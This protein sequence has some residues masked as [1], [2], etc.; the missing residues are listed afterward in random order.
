M[1]TYILVLISVFLTFEWTFS[2]NNKTSFLETEV[3][4][5]IVSGS[6]H[7]TLTTPIPFKK[8]TVAL[9][10]AGSGPT[11]RNGNNVAME[12]NSL[13]NLAHDLAKNGIATLRYDKRGIAASQQALTRE[14]DLRFEDLVED[15]KGWVFQL[16]KDKKY[17]RIVVIGHSEGS[18]IGM[19]AAKEADQFISLAGAG[20]S[21]DLILKEQLNNQ[22]QML[23]DVA[24]PIIDSLKVG[25]TVDKINPLLQSLFRKSVQPY[26]ISWFKY[27]PAQ[28]LKK[29]N[30]PTLLIQGDK[31]IQVGVEDA[32][33]LAQ[34]VPSA[35]LVIIN[36]MNHIFKIIEGDKKENMASYKDPNLSNAMQLTEEIT[37]FIQKK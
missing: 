18:L 1:K 2:Q 10:I 9:I 34:A 32:K 3:S 35:K 7:G 19:L 4:L 23:K 29:L 21:A 11:D 33:L 12:N 26:L 13:K 24:F 22:P 28:E 31:D 30:K 36:K 20:K 25:K 15:A 6:L 16:K 8:G 5:K 17:K 14:E 27:D 37:A